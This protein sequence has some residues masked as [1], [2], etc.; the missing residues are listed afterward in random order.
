MR[1]S[2]KE[3]K[4]QSVL[5]D[6]LDE[7]LVGYLAIIQSDGTPRAIPL[8]FVHIDGNLYFHGARGGEKYEVLRNN[9]KIS[10]CVVQELS[11]I[12]SHF[13]GQGP[14]EASHFYRSAM[15]YGSGVIID[16]SET[17]RDVLTALLEKYQPGRVE[18]KFDFSVP[19]HEIGVKTTAVFRLTMDSWKVK[20]NIGAYLSTS[21][22]DRVI[23]NLEASNDPVARLTATLMR[24]K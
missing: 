23:K 13:I 21:A 7:V 19:T 18:N 1:R 17:E 5:Y 22:R 11:Y 6:L 15:I 16:D 9:P 3:V 12:P 4:D 24:N 8:N 20:E 14:C 10:F 2:D